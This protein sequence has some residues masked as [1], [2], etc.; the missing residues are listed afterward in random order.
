MNALESDTVRQTLAHP[1]VHRHWIDQYYATESPLYEAMF[2]RIMARL[3]PRPQAVFLDAGCGDGTHTIRL[4]R[5]GYSVVA[6]DFA[7]YVLGEAR[8]KV[9]ASG[10]DHRVQFEHASLL[11][12]PFA[13]D[14]FEY[15]LCWGVLMHVP[16]V[17]TAIS[18]LARVVK[19]NGVVIVN[20]NNMWSIESV[21]VRIVRRLLG[22]SLVRRLQG[23]DPAQLHIT[24]AGAEFWRQTDAGPLICREARIP[25]LVSQFEAKGLVVEARMPGALIEREGEMPTGRLKDWVQRLN[26][27][28][29]KRVR[30]PQ[31]A[32]ENILLLRK[33]VR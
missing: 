10:L 4:A 33:V 29:F 28:W 25:W 16:E 5:R 6:A 21:L 1:D 22:R 32:S 14:S 7:E 13:D 9:T 30:L 18:E 24:A 19:P 20:E 3:S 31:P 23:K 26:V 2:D 15:V 8:K 12:L 27:A 11:H 17:E